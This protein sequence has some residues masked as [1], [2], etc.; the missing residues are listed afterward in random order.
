SFS[1]LGPFLTRLVTL[2]ILSR[3]LVV[4]ALRRDRVS[5]SDSTGTLSLGELP[6]GL[7]DEDLTWVPV[8]SYSPSEGGLPLPP[9]APNEVYSLA[10]EVPVDD[11]YFDDAK[12]PRSIL[13][14]ASVSL[15]ALLDT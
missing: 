2:V 12:L 11:I 3:P 4:I 5:L 10:W 15:S 9:D 14:P 1:V 6:S 7:T 13:S 8:H